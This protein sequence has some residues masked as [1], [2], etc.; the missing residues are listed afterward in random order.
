MSAIPTQPFLGID[1]G[2][3]PP[4]P[5]TVLAGLCA[6][7]NQ[8]VRPR[9][10]RRTIIDGRERPTFEKKV[11]K[12]Q[13]KSLFRR[14][15]A[16]APLKSDFLVFSNFFHKSGPFSAVYYR[17]STAPRPYILIFRGAEACQD[18]SGPRRRHSEID[19]QKR[20]C[21]NCWHGKVVWKLPMAFIYLFTRGNF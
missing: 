5:G 14:A 10:R 9:R 6:S 7:K 16:R 4:G 15:R 13:K 21:G 2:M 19:S 1:L 12:I 3:P 17:S 8:Y 20:L 11:G 18:R